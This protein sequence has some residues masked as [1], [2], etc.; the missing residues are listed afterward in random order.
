MFQYAT[1]FNQTF[2]RACA[3]SVQHAIMASLRDGSFDSEETVTVERK[4]T[5]GPYSPAQRVIWGLYG[6]NGKSGFASREVRAL[7]A[8]ACRPPERH[9]QV[10]PLS[11]LGAREMA[12]PRL[13]LFPIVSLRR[14]VLEKF[15]FSLPPTVWAL[16]AD[17][18]TPFWDVLSHVTYT[19]T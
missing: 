15:F 2:T 3:L 7:P 6:G 8:R 10:S 18:P 5:I 4:T 13:H 17:S 1:S 16:R 11:W 12:I 9:P 19:N 14:T